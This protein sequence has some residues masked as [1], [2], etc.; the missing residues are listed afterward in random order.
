VLRHRLR[1]DLV[2]LIGLRLSNGQAAA[3]CADVAGEARV[4]RRL[5]QQEDQHDD[6]DHEQ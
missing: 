2:E 6:E 5:R 4:D 1:D 3:R